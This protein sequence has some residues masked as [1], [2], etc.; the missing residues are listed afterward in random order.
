MA[1]EGAWEQQERKAK[2]KLGSAVAFLS[3]FS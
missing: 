3:V 1:Q 2:K